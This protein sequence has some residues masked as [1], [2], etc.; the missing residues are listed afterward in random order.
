MSRDYHIYM[1]AFRRCLSFFRTITFN[2]AFSPPWAFAVDDGDHSFLSFGLRIYSISC[3]LF[4]GFLASMGVYCRWQRPPVFFLSPFDFFCFMDP[5]WWFSRLN[6]RLLSMTVTNLCWF[7][8]H[9]F[10]AFFFVLRP[11]SDLIFRVLSMEGSACPIPTGCRYQ[12]ILASSLGM[13]SPL[14]VYLWKLVTLCHGITECDFRKCL[15]CSALLSLCGS[16]CCDRKIFKLIL[17]STRLCSVWLLCT[18]VLTE[19]VMDTLPSEW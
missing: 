17:R 12:P 10:S 5:I 9:P 13:F 16:I 18:W 2:S 14:V 1:F 19:Q 11:V 15:L 3:V 6:G 7:A 8:R 4:G